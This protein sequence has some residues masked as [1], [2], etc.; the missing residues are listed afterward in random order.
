[1]NLD[2]WTKLTLAF[3]LLALLACAAPAGGTRFNLTDGKVGTSRVELQAQAR[4]SRHVVAFFTQGRGAWMVH[5]RHHSCSSVTG[6]RRR[7]VCK[8][9]RRTL[10]AHRWLLTVVD[11]KLAAFGTLM[12]ASWYGGPDGFLGQ[13]MACGG[14]LHAGS[15]VVA[16]RTLPCFTRISVCYRGRCV[17]AVVQ[18]HGPAAWTGRDIDLGPGVARALGFGGVGLVRV[19]VLR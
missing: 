5:R 4:K 3:A 11:R 7:P 9:A 18:D 6:T 17:R 14:T 19:A 2:G 16:H 10:K 12:L 15:M 13:T 8:I 1:M